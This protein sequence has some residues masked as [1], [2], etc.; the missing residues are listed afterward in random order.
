MSASKAF[1]FSLALLLGAGGQVSAQNTVAFDEPV[2]T[3]AQSSG[4]VSGA[5]AIGNAG[6]YFWVQGDFGERPGVLGNYAS[7][8]SFAPIDFMDSDNQFF[9]DSQVMVNDDAELGTS[10][11]LGYRHLVDPWGS[12]FGV[13]GF[14]TFDQSRNKFSYNQGGV[15]AEWLTE[16]FQVTANAYLPF[17]SQ[18][19]SVGPERR[20]NNS[21]FNGNHMGFINFQNAETQLRGADLDIAVPIPG[22]QWL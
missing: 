4:S 13:N 8:G 16:F 2:V 21:M 6:G 15:G 18:P 10:V 19:N 7:F 14:Y 17:D 12:I 5:T 22:A 11:G 20:T 3:G 1:A 9:I